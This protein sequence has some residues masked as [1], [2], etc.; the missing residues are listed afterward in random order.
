MENIT[1][2]RRFRKVSSWMA[3]A[4]TAIENE[5]E[6]IAV[7]RIVLKVLH[8]METHHLTQKELADKLSVSPQYINKFLHGQDDIKVSTALRYG[9]ILGI[10]L[11]EIPE[12]TTQ[13]VEPSMP[14]VI[15]QKCIVK[16]Y[17]ME[18]SGFNTYSSIHNPV[19]KQL[20]SYDN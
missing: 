15:Y 8:Y 6:I 12:E 16:E 18:S 14:V 7:K 2:K 20:F 9:K 11:I 4:A 19:N 17:S 1:K 3:D 13:R 5:D 10:K